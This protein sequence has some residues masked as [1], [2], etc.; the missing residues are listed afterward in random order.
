MKKGHTG[1]VTV[2]KTRSFTAVLEP[3]QTGMGWVVA[4]IPFDVAGAW[5]ERRGLRVRGEIEGVAIK[6]TL[7]A[8]RGGGG[9]F[10]L[11]NRKMQAAAR[12]KPGAKV[13]ILLEPDLED[14]PAVVPPE[15]A[16]A[17]KGDRRLRPWFDGLAVS[18]R[19]DVG[20]WVMEPKS[21]ESREKRAEQMAEWL[22]LALEG[23]QETPPILKA[24][25]RRQP[26]AQAGWER[27]TPVQR[28]NHLLGIFHYRGAEAR[29]KRA[30]QAVEEALK[31]AKRDGKSQS[32][33][34]SFEI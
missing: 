7:M 4:R 10:L 18:L 20:K 23:E 34:F 19:R 5:P 9:H 15:L 1:G 16:K 32:E 13:R 6:T 11:V 29:E 25:F 31:V 12:V 14:R 26:L 28:R 21:A 30:A 2:G 24:A 8:Y 27:M 3:L 22:L 17:L 33:H